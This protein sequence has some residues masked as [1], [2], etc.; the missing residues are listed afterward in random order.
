MDKILQIIP[1]DGW[2]A[3]YKNSTGILFEQPLVCFALVEDKDKE[4]RIVGMGCD[5]TYIDSV[6][7]VSNFAGYTKSSTA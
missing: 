5:D 1:A 7:G 2:C 3:L 6:D 4:Q